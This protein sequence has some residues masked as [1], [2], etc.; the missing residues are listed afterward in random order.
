MNKIAKALAISTL[1]LGSMSAIHATV[2][3]SENF[4]EYTAG[5]PVPW[6]TDYS[7]NWLQVVAYDFDT[8]TDSSHM[9]SAGPNQYGS[10]SGSNLSSQ[11]VARSTVFDGPG[12]QTGQMSFAFYDPSSEPHS[13]NGFVFRI[14]NQDSGNAKAAFAIFIQNGELILA[15]GSDII[16][17]ATSFASYNQNEANQLDIVFNNSDSPLTY[18]GG[19]IVAGAMDVY[20][21]GELVGDDL[22]R[23]GSLGTGVNIRSFNITAKTSPAFTGTMYLDDIVVDDS[24]SI[25]EI[26]ESS[27]YM[28]I[29]PLVLLALRR[30]R[31][32]RS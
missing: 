28:G 26:S 12:T 29:I 15:Y 19:T 5:E 3:F 32:K 7:E 11:M 1:L 10:L 27:L 21:N 22:G 13:G 6:N 18:S 31:N 14:S 20:L 8:E 9:F 16:P 4:D 17:S 30:R 23:A 2:I 25:P 24:I